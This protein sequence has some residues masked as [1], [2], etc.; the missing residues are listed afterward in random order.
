MNALL[1]S[2]HH[3]FKIDE[4]RLS[5]TVRGRSVD[6]V[7]SCGDV[8]YKVLEEL[9][10]RFHS[11]KLYAVHGNHCP[12]TPFPEPVIDLHRTIVQHGLL[13]FSGFEGTPQYKDTGHHLYDDLEV[14]CVMAT[15]PAVDVM[16]SHAP[17][18]GIHDGEDFAHIGFEAFRKFIDQRKPRYWIHGHSHFKNRVT[19]LDETFVISVF[20]F[21]FVQLEPAPTDPVTYEVE[22]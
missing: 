19:P 17:P 14:E 16:V 6:L 18:R 9:S 13:W 4:R 2:D 11:A 20:G 12:A 8:P 7:I 1:V 3:E 15:F 5:D 10:R 21:K 22:L